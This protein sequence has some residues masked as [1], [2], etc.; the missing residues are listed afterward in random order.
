[1]AIDEIYERQSRIPGWEQER[2][3][4]TDVLVLGSDILAQE[5][6]VN[7]TG[8]GI[9]RIM[10]LSESRIK[11]TDR[12]LLYNKDKDKNRGDYRID[13]MAEYLTELNPNMRFRLRHG[14]FTKAWL[15]D[16]DPKIIIDATNNPI[17]KK[18]AFNHCLEN[19]ISFVTGTTS[20]DSG[21]MA[22]YHPYQKKSMQERLEGMIERTFFEQSQGTVTSGVIAGLMADEIRKLQLKLDKTDY[23]MYNGHNLYYN[24]CNRERN[25]FHNNVKRIPYKV[26]KKFN[27]LVVGAGAVG[28]SLASTLAMSGFGNIDIIDGDTIKP[29]NL[30]RQFNFKGAVGRNKS[31][32]L[33]EKIKQYNNVT[34]THPFT[35][36]LAEEDE[37]LFAEGNGSGKYHVVF[38]AVDKIEVRKLINE[39]ARKHNLIYVD[40]GTSYT[41]GQLQLYVPG[42]N[43]CIDCQT[44]YDR[45]IEQRN[46]KLESQTEMTQEGCEM[47]APSVIVPNF[48]V[49]SAMVAEAVR[50][51]YSTS[52]KNILDGTFYYKAFGSPRIGVNPVL[53]KKD[54]GM[55]GGDSHEVT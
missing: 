38:G 40:G 36:F 48:I 22:C 55:C 29:H 11:G 24:T 31:E 33:A 16:F 4:N 45:M 8:L 13:H 42:K 47:A 19:R 18:E 32:T 21:F 43:R 28:N 49:G 35:K 51:L 53:Y 46:R 44:D 5:L 25:S 12:N 52:R 3:S 39:Y 14:R 10:L 26:L 1:M 20:E 23:P 54:C 41:A 37:K 6:L 17:S 27:A 2:L 15:L 7:L 50:A 30:S 9:E 34:R